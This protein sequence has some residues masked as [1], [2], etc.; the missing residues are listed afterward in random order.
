[1][2]TPPPADHS[3]NGWN[4]AYLE[5]LYERW[6]ADPSS[7]DPAWRPFFQGFDLGR[8]EAGHAEADDAPAL[9]AAAGGGRTA[10]DVAHT[11]QGKVDS[12]IYHY[13][14]NGHFAADLDP[15]GTT[16]PFPWQLELDSFGLAEAD[17]H[18]IPI[19]PNVEL[20]ETIRLVMETIADRLAREYTGTPEV[21]FAET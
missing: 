16:R 11:R 1:M 19:I 4:G 14:D 7:V 8:V 10:T 18:Q 15:L 12:L 20:S 9:P 2:T 17:R 21:V 3:V 13:R 6:H 5:A